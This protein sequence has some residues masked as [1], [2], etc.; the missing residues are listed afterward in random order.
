MDL[1]L[2]LGLRLPVGHPKSPQAH[3][4]ADRKLWLK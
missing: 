2:E 3:Y 4:R 1:H